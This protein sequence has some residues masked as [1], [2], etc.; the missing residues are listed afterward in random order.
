MPVEFEFQMRKGFD[1]FTAFGSRFNTIVERDLVYLPEMLGHGYIKRV[2]LDN[3]NLYI[4]NYTLKQEFILKRRPAL[5]D[6]G[7]TIK[8]GRTSFATIHNQQK[9]D[10][11]FDHVRN[12]EIELATSNFSSELRL[13]PN[14]QINLI[15]V[16]VS[17]ETVLNLLKAEESKLP[18]LEMI[19]KQPSFVMRDVITPAIDHTLKQLFEINSFTDMPYLLY[20]IKTH[21]L[22][23][24]F[25][26]RLAK[27]PIKQILRIS[28]D[29]AEKINLV[30]IALLKD[31]TQCPQLWEL[32]EISGFG[33]TKLKKLFNQIFGESIYSHFQTNRMK[34]AANLLVSFSVSETGTK[35]GFTNLSHFT[36]LFE[37]HYHIKPKQFKDRL[38]WQPNVSN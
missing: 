30:R 15:V 22:I 20:K 1:F 8:F 18:F 33:L 32:S 25:F 28:K 21:E 11:F 36:R 12:F 35:L 14:V 2:V 38:I 7:L 26:K 3:F 31:L 27:R 24:H 16:G 37:K 29:D 34:E 4:H 19:E 10:P 23:Y 9:D 13:Q 6:N 5:T 17:R